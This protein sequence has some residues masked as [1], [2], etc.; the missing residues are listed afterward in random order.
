MEIF[1][2]DFITTFTV[3]GIISLIGMIFKLI[4]EHKRNKEQ[5]KAD[6]DNG[7]DALK[8]CPLCGS[9][10]ISLGKYKNKCAFVNCEDCG[11]SIFK[12]T[13]DE[14]IEAWNKRTI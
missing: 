3:F 8:P 2:V 7:L 1:I 14:A 4:K 10:D 9:T 11:A 6:M 12:T 5:N 13:K